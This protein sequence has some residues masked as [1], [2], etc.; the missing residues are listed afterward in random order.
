MEGLRQVLRG[1]KPQPRGALRSYAQPFRFHLLQDAHDDMVPDSEPSDIH[2]NYAV[3]TRSMGK[4]GGPAPADPL[5]RTDSRGPTPADL[6]LLH[7]RQGHAKS[8][9]DCVDC[10]MG[11]MQA[12]RTPSIQPTDRCVHSSFGRLPDCRGHERSSTP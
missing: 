1:T 6:L 9:Q 8:H 7:R 2:F 10:Q 5:P 11:K 4:L 3:Q 12:R